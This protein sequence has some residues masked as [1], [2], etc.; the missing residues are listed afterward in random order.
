MTPVPV[1]FIDGLGPST[2]LFIGVVAVLLFGERLPEVGR[3]IG[4]QFAGLKKSMQ[5]LQN[6]FRN[7]AMGDALNPLS[8]SS[9]SYSS[10]SSSYGSS[11]Y[12]T[13]PEDHEMVTAPKF[14]P[15][16]AEG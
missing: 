4:K 7:A 9:S 16:K 10:S 6:E 8:G 13:D 11:S 1:A 3:S 14:I 2:L 15:P 5:G 12:K